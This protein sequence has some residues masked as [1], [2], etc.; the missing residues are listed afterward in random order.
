MAILTFLDPFALFL[1]G[2]GGSS[3]SS[4]SEVSP[5]HSPYFVCNPHSLARLP[6]LQINPNSLLIQTQTQSPT[7][8]PTQTP[9]LARIQQDFGA[10]QEQDS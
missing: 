7:Q 2:Q 4:E 10:G 8:T 5:E 6:T 1:R 9:T 3:H